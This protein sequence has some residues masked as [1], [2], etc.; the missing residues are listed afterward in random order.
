MNYLVNYFYISFYLLITLKNL[1]KENNDEE[2]N[3]RNYSSKNNPI[4]LIYILYF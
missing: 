3:Y 1:K 4:K 2:L